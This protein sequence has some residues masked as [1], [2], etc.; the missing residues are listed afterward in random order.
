MGARAGFVYKTEDDLIATFQPGRPPSAFTVPYAFN[1]NGLDGR[2]GTADDR[3]LTFYGLPNAQAAAFPITE[4][5]MNVDQYARY[6][7]V[8]VSM[9]K[10][11]C[12]RWSASAGFGYTLDA[13]LSQRSRAQSEQSGRRGPDA[14]DLQGDR[15]VRR[16]MADPDLSGAAASVGVQLRAD[17][18]DLGAGGVGR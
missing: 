17:G 1:D 9:N 12:S 16:A 10:R 2:A 13:R 8:E 7:T 4:T 6:K 3:S 11:Y 18:H 14:V 15:F 5:Q